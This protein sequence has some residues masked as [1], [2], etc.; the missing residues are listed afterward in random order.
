MKA[1]ALTQIW[2]EH[3]SPH[4]QRE[5]WEWAAE[6]GELPSNYAVS[7]PLDITTCPMIKGPL[8]ALRR[9]TVRHVIAMA[10]VQCLKTL[11]GELWLLWSIVNDPGP[12]QWLQ[13]TNEDA[14]EHVKERFWDLMDAFPILKKFLSQRP[15]NSGDRSL[16]FIRFKHMFLRIEGAESQANLQRK[17]I[18]LQMRSEIWQSKYWQPG[19]LKEADSRLTQFVHNS[20]KYT[21]SQ[22]G[23]AAELEVDDMD[24]T[25][26]L[27]DQNEWEFSCLSCGKRQP[28][29]FSHIRA[30][31]T[32]AAMRWDVTERT[33]RPNGEWR[34]AELEKTVRYE[35]IH[36]GHR[37]QDDP[38]IRRRLTANGQFTPRN[39]DAEPTTASFTWNQLAMPNL[40]WF[41]TEIGGVQN[42]LLAHESAKRGYDKLLKEF[43]MKVLAQPYNPA[44]HGLF[45]RIE[46]V[47]ILTPPSPDKTI[48]LEGVKFV[49]RLGGVDVQLDHFWFL[50]EIWS[51]NGDSLTLHAEKLFSW[52]DVADRQKKFFIADENMCV[53]TGHRSHEVIVE[54]TRHGHWGLDSSKRRW[55]LCWRALAGSDQTEFY[56]RPQNAKQRGQKIA[57]PYSWPAAKGDPCFGMRSNDPRRREFHGG[58]YCRKH[59]WSNPTIK[60]VAIRRRDRKADGVKNL[61][62]RGDWNEEFSRQLHSQKKVL[63]PGKY[64]SPRWKWQSFRDDHLLDCRCMIIVRAFQLHLIQGIPSPPSDKDQEQQ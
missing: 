38:I 53:D 42:F 4:D 35:C 50:A 58:Q 29:L 24:R 30:D 6:E 61:T 21:E 45:S 48:E 49:H 12:A 41:K 13:T 56:W 59:F 64:G 43:F 47:E 8:S 15:S 23:F 1:D 10:G 52:E 11:I 18:K 40:S 17:S 22:A 63:V 9:R 51:A 27:G 55:W 25:Y 31:G 2:R 28:Y 20:K 33:R 37:H 3:F 54:C 60:D 16:G 39:P 62:A 34:W 57:L 44:L 46:S 36:C 32:R 26:R 5:I 7:G 14:K 19:K